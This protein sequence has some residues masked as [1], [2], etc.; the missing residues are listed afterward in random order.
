MVRGVR[1]VLWPRKNRNEADI[2]GC[3][4]CLEVEI[5][6]SPDFP[7]Q[8]TLLQVCHRVAAVLVICTTM[9]A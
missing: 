9:M 5:S 2:K 7:A 1:A 3:V 6:E 8:H 4:G